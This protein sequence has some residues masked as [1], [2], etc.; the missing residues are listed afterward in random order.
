MS[1]ASII[2]VCLSM[3]LLAVMLLLAL[4]LQYIAETLESQVELVAYLEEDSTLANQQLVR[5]KISVLPGVAEAELVTKEQALEIL[6]EQFGD[7]A[8]LLEGIEQTNALRASVNVKVPEPEYVDEVAR[9]VRGMEYVSD[10]RYEKEV[11]EKLFRVT[12]AM[13]TGGLLLVAML[14]IGTLFIISNTVRIA[15]F[16]RRREI[17]IMKLVGATDMFIRFPFLLEGAI[18][19]FFGSLLAF[20]L[21]VWGYS[22]L[23]DE[24]KQTMPFLPVLTSPGLLVRMAQVL[25]GFGVIIGIIGSNISLRKYMRV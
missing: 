2:T 21:I 18:L 20:G 22:W 25:L 6:R 15:V 9:A 13:R 24:I 12:S 3:F 23:I 17:G 5:E 1:L 11:L 4:N 8:S 19:G 14:A 16:A 7:Q 10:V